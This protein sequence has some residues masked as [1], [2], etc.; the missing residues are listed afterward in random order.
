MWWF[1]KKIAATKRHLAQQPGRQLR[2]PDIYIQHTKRRAVRERGNRVAI[3]ED[4]REIEVLEGQDAEASEIGIQMRVAKRDG[5]LEPVDLNKIVR[6]VA[7]CAAGLENVDAMRV[8]TRTIS[9]LVDGATT[10]ELDN[11]SIRTAA[12]FIA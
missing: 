1:R 11:L 6:A 3:S 2:R 12:A 7:R 10:E 9:G 8:A 5:T 4:L